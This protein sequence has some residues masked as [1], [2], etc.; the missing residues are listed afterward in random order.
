MQ[1]NADNTRD[2]GTTSSACRD[3]G[4]TFI[5]LLV[6]IVLLGLVVVGALTAMR[7]T[8]IGTRIERDHAKA[9]QWLQSAIGVLNERARV[10]CDLVL[11]GYV[12]GEEQV[13]LEYQEYVRSNVASPVGWQASSQ[14]LI[15]DP[16]KIW[17]GQQYW[18]PDLSPEPCYDNIGYELQLITIQVTSPDGDI[19]ETIELVKHD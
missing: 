6:T 11:P 12:D 1:S 10:G 19:L 17:D 5:E 15:V 14:L 4:S 16:V 18:D 13:R 2:Q 7:A 9:Q 3:S 8:V